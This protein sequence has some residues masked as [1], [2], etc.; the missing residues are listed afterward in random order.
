MQHNRSTQ[1]LSLS[2]PSLSNSA[3]SDL[4]KA[5]SKLGHH[6]NLIELAH[7]VGQSELGEILG[8][9]G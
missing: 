2:S 8:V 9:S 5:T 4:N 1:S 7:N 3:L 6:A